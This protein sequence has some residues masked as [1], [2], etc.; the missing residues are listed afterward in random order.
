MSN[1]T[2]KTETEYDEKLHKQFFTLV[3]TKEEGKKVNQSNVARALGYSNAVITLYKKM[4]YKGKIS[5]LEKKIRSW[6]SRESRRKDQVKIPV[7]KTTVM[8]KIRKAI[9]IA[10]EERDIAVIVGDAGTGKTTAIRHYVKESQAAIL[11]EVDPAFSKSVLVTEIARKVGVETK[12]STHQRIDRIIEALRNRDAVL[13]FDEADYLA[14]QS[15]ELIRRVIN[16]KSRTGVVLVGLPRLEYQ[17]RNL[18][19][20]H[21]QLSS[22]VGVLLKVNHMTKKDA[23]KIL[24]TVWSNIST[25]ATKTF[26]SIASGSVR[27]LS[28]LIER[29]NRTL[30]L[31]NLDTPTTDAVE[32][33]GDLLMK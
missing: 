25:E 19:N 22:R 30:I 15:L 7:V 5:I 10:H 2:I 3:G 11:I 6:L 26:V 8:S 18:R 9:G 17:L 13:I 33:A 14:P 21:Q 1:N 12:G 29:V 24:T 27:T 28:K 23:Q 16:D 31:N 4:S 20:D 32:I